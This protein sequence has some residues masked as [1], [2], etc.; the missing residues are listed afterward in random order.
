MKRKTNIYY[1]KLLKKYTHTSW[2]RRYFTTFTTSS[3]MPADLQRG[4][5]YSTATFARQIYNS[6]YAT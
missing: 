1:L 5:L 6:M 4:P 2:K 3:Q